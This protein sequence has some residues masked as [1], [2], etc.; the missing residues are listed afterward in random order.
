M[1]IDSCIPSQSLTSE[2][3]RQALMLFIET[4]GECVWVEQVPDEWLKSRGI[5][6][7]PDVWLVVTDGFPD[8]DVIPINKVS[9]FTPNPF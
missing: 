9:R 2:R 8:P 5:Q 7:N 1:N 4:Y 3:R 6:L